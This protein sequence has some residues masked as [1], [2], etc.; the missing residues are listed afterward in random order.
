MENFYDQTIKK[1]VSDRGGKFLNHQFQKLSEECGFEHLKSPAET[2]QHNGFAERVNKTLLK[3]ACCLLNGSNLTNSY[4]A[5]AVSTATLLSN[6]VPTSSRLN[7]SPYNLWRGS[8]RQIKKLRVFGCA[9]GVLLGCTNDNTAY[10]VLQLSNKKVVI[11]RHVVFD[12]STLPSLENLTSNCNSALI[13]PE[14]QQAVAE[15]VDEVL[16]ADMGLVDEFLPIKPDLDDSSRMVDEIQESNEAGA[17]E[18]SPAHPI[19]ALRIKVIGPG[20]PTI[21]SSDIDSFN[22]LPYNR[23]PR[24]LLSAHNDAP[25]TFKQAINSWNKAIEKELASMIQLQVWDVVDLKSEYKLVG[26]TWVFRTK[27]DHLNKVIKHKARLCAQ[28]FTQ[29]PILDFSKTYAPTGRMN[30]LRT[31]IAFAASK[32]LS[33]HQINIK[34]TFLNAPLAEKVYLS[35]PQGLDLDRRKECLCLNKAIYG[36]KQAPLAWYQRLK[37]WLVKVGFVECLLDPCV[38]HRQGSTPLWLYVHVDNIAIFGNNVRLFKKEIAE[39]FDT[40]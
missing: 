17:A 34:S 40:C 25:R 2:P 13:I 1:L 38:F 30:L 29:T 10:W 37:D 5:E 32:N 7:R 20:H 39:E 6:L 36:L 31:L 16:P 8:P 9:E 15:E 11:S 33:F 19:S 24:A 26:T 35:I 23:R 3:K 27:G 4:W 22:I 14:H 18:H 12:K 28:G 21:I